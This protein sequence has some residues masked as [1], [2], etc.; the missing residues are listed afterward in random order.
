MDKW[1]VSFC[2]GKSRCPYY[3]IAFSCGWPQRLILFIGVAVYK[4]HVE[5]E[6][7]REGG[8]EQ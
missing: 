7:G 1:F 8:P 5:L 2:H 6:I 3:A 4:Y